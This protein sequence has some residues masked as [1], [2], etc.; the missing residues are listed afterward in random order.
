M[1]DPGA[2][3]A[4]AGELMAD[5]AYGELRDRIVTLRIPPGAPINED[6][7]GRELQ[8]G[9]TPVREAIKRLSHANLVTVYPS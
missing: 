9:R 7:L 6:A 4:A 3:R 5:R 1:A 2:G 8:M